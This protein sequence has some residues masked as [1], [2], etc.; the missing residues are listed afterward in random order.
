MPTPDELV[1]TGKLERFA[2]DLLPG[3]LECRRLFMMPRVVTYFQET[4]PGLAS[5][6]YV[7]GALTPLDQADEFLSAF[8]R[9]DQWFQMPPHS[10]KP[11]DLGIWELCTSDL[12]FFGW[13]WRQGTFTISAVG[14]AGQTKD[15]G[16]YP[17]YRAQ[18]VND[19]LTLD[20]DPPPFITGKLTDVL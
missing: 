20:L 18:A 1:Q 2:P 16:L 5:D 11:E 19:R 17:G 13:F 10:M 4:L 14:L 7:S 3:D 15:K 12:R 6:G 9:S 8:A